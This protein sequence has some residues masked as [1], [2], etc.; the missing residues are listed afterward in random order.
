[1]LKTIAIAYIAT[2]AIA[3]F[4]TARSAHFDR[5]QKLFQAGV[6]WLLPVV[7]SVVILVFHTVVHRNM[8]TRAQP[9]RPNPNSK[10]ILADH[11]DHD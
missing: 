7:G 9:D 4:V 11:T 1:M 2:S 3:T 8:T 5:T 6:I 10:H